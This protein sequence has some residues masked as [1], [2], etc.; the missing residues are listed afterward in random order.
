MST[1]S[2]HTPPPAANTRLRLDSIFARN[3]GARYRASPP[4]PSVNLTGADRTR[5]SAV[6]QSTWDADVVKRVAKDTLGNK[7]ASFSGSEPHRR[8]LWDSLFASLQDSFESKDTAS[9][10]IF[11]LVDITQEVNPVFNELLLRSLVSL[12][13]PHSPARRWVEASARTSPKDGK[14]ALLEITKRL[15]PTGHK[16]MRHHEELLSISFSESA[17]PEPLVA[18]FDECLKAI[19]ASGAGPLDGQHAKR[20]LLSALDPDFYREVI[21]PLRLDT[22]LDKVAIEE[23]YVHVCEVWWC[24]HPEGPTTKHPPSLPLSAAYTSRD[25]PETDFLSEFDRVLREAFKLLDVLR[26]SARDPV[27]NP[28]PPRHDARD[29]DRRTGVSFPPSK[30]R[31]ARNRRPNGVFHGR[32]SFRNRGYRFAEKP[33]PK[34]GCWS[35]SYYNKKHSASNISFHSLSSAFIQECPVCP[36]HFHDTARCP[37]VGGVCG[38][39]A[40]A[41]AQE[42]DEVVSAFQAAFDDED[43]DAFAELCQLHS[44]PRVRDGPEPLTYPEHASLGLRAQYAGLVSQSPADS[45]MSARLAEARSV[46]SGLR[47]A[48]AAARAAAGDPPDSPSFG[49]VSVPQVVPPPPPANPTAAVLHSAAAT[50]VSAPPQG[51]ALAPRAAADPA[52][53]QSPFADSFMDHFALRVEQDPGLHF[54]SFTLPSSPAIWGPP[55]SVVNSDS[56]SECEPESA[57]APDPPAAPAANRIGVSPAPRFARLA[58]GLLSVLTV[59]SCATTAHG[60]VVQQSVPTVLTAVHPVWVSANTCTIP[61]EPAPPALPPDPPACF[62]DPT[63]IPEPSAFPPGYYFWSSGFWSS[64]YWT[65]GLWFW[66]TGFWIWFWTSGSG[67]WLWTDTFDNPDYFVNNN[68][69]LCSPV[70]HFRSG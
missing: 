38:G 25:A 47:D 8:V 49:T 54:D 4:T 58:A 37:A 30:W 20:Q 57:P 28:P 59:L 53:F 65:A 40:A 1:S 60:S 21:T 61:P 19:A 5:A 62:P 41:A 10:T 32:N 17:D 2:V 68:S 42:L 67:F 15:M 44:P 36:G 64:G 43:D 70:D 13:T 69:E 39:D 35:Q 16:P 18:Q 66:T 48:T 27:P 24:A 29:R 55:L 14:R 6:S 11:D 26:D 50:S 3:V 34:D 51:S 56:D 33:L 46:L 45:G 52:N 23:I 7:S 31:D 9:A 63:P 22:E 12:T